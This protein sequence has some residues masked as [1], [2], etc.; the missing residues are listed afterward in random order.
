MPTKKWSAESAATP[1]VTDKLMLLTDPAGTPGNGTA[2][3]S[4]LGVAT[5]HFNLQPIDSATTV[6][7]GLVY[8]WEVL[9]PAAI[10]GWNITGISAFTRVASTSGDIVFSI[11]KTR[12]N[13]TGNIWNGYNLT[14]TAVTIPAGDNWDDQTWV[15]NTAQDDLA[16]F[17]TFS[18]N[19]TSA[20]TNAQGL[21]VVLTAQKT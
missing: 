17:D 7:T 5:W 16:Q 14:S 6:T 9:V 20:G 1:V 8:S 11:N 21:T 18:C 10:A 2:T 4:S 3:L 19:V 15:I 13:G 12:E